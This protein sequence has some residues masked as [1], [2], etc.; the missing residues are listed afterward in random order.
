MM[1]FSVSYYASM[2]SAGRGR[3]RI[4]NM[5]QML[6]GAGAESQFPEK[7]DVDKPDDPDDPMSDVTSATDGN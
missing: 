1:D 7:M 5:D 6:H 4:P 3:L 2:M